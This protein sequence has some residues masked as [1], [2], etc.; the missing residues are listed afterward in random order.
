MLC[1]AINVLTTYRHRNEIVKS[2]Q[3]IT[4]YSILEV[5]CSGYRGG[6]NIRIA[7]LDKEYHVGVSK[8]QC[9]GIMSTKLYYDRQHDTVFEKDEINMSQI[10]FFLTMFA[11]SLLLWTYPEVRKMK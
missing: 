8:K 2:E 3:P 5:H 7:Y 4:D 6:S 10:V 9:K 1:L 11:Y